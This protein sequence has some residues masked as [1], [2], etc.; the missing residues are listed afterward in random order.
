[1]KTKILKYSI[2][3][4]GLCSCNSN[5]QTKK[6]STQPKPGKA[7]AVFAEGCF[8]CS[9]HIFE[10]V[11]GVQ[12]AVSGYSGGNTKNPSYEQ[13]GSETTG[14]A[15]SVLVYYDPNVVSYS[16]L[17]DAFFASQDP[18]TP[19]QQGPDRG[20]SYRS[21]AFYRNDVEKKIIKD[22]ILELENKKVFSK[23]IVT[24]VLPLSDF[25][26]AEDYHQDYIK[27]HANGEN[28]Y[29]TNVSIPRYELFK[30]TY[31]GKLKH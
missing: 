11:A 6:L 18:T 26:Q 7:I 22:K 23:P 10:A 1:M 14:H 29:V 15:E 30:K 5:G 21:I 2:L 3:L 9:E 28:P 25:Y 12:D 24:E 20:S 31:K 17:V 16:Q 13:V 4:L 8:W 19:N 27:K